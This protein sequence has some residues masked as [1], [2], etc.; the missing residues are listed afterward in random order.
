MWADTIDTL[1]GRWHLGG[2]NGYSFVGAMWKRQAWWQGR[3]MPGG[4]LALVW[5]NPVTELGCERWARGEVGLMVVA[6]AALNGGQA[7]LRGMAPAGQ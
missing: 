2:C 3:W 7:G 6:S 5:G 4:L 1:A